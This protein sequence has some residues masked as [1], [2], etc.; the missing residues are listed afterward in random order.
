MERKKTIPIN[1][2]FYDDLHAKWHDSKDH[3]VALL[4]AENSL[5]NPWIQQILHNHFSNNCKILDIGCGGG[6]L[7]NFLADQS[8]EVFGVDLSTQSLE[9]AK[10]LDKTKKVSYQRASAYELP[11]GDQIFS[12]VCAM[13]LLE[14]VENPALVVKEASR[15]LR[16]D[17]LFFFHTFNRNLLSY[18]M[19]IKGVEW[20]FLNPPSNMHVYPLFIKPKELK[21]I[22]ENHHLKFCEILGMRPDYS[23]KAFWKMVFQ[24]KVE[25]DFRFV[26]TS[27]LKTGYCGYA[28]KD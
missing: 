21:K 7:T 24:R 10:Q 1:N 23:Q 19:V 9:V 15:V 3:P 28:I 26:F 13:D 16:K 12:V 6:F 8:H 14:H 27:S 17:G 11:F 2:A 22:C 18:F 25:E 20:C 5:R 4:R